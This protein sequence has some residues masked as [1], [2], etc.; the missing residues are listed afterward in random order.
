MN[1]IHN[2][3]TTNQVTAGNLKSLVRESVLT[4]INRHA[5]VFEAL[6]RHQTPFGGSFLAGNR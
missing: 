3:N 2:H 6:T 4:F 5:G 1:F